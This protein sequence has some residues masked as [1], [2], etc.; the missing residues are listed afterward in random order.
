MFPAIDPGYEISAAVFAMK[1][2]S[3]GSVRL[4]ARDPESPLAI[5]HGFLRDDAD[6]DVLAEGFDALRDFVRAELPRRYTGTELR[7]GAELDAGTY[8]RQSARGFFHPTGTCAIGLVVDE[9]L[10]VLGF[11][12]LYVA[13][14]SVM[15]TIPRANTHLSTVAIAE[16]AADWI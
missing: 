6:A 3:R 10:R 5:D 7:P 11:E 13:D 4:T 1:P 14:A 8:V 9:R 16:R 15:P 12:N 2:R